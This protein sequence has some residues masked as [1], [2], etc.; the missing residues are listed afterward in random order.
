MNNEDVPKNMGN[1]KAENCTSK[2]TI[3]ISGSY[4]DEYL[5][6]AGKKIKWKYRVVSLTSF[7]KCNDRTVSGK[8]F[9]E[10]SIA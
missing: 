6:L 3:R 7:C 2:M 1:K 10:T 4:D 5:S 9:N 8:D